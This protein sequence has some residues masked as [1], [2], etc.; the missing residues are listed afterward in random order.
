M[1]GN[2]ITSS[3]SQTAKVGAELR[4]ETLETLHSLSRLIKMVFQSYLLDVVCRHQSLLPQDGTSTTYHPQL[5]GIR[6]DTEQHLSHC[7]GIFRI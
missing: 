5:L 4:G 1:T 6:K 7:T 2:F 3:V